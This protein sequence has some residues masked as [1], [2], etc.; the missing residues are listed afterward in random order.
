MSAHNF[1]PEEVRYEVL[2]RDDGTAMLT[3]GG[4]VMWSSDGDDEF[5]EDFGDELID[6]EDIPDL[7]DWLT[8]SG[9]LPPGVEP[10]IEDESADGPGDEDDDEEDDE[11]ESGEDE[12]D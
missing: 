3:C 1:M 2:L 6:S 8:D 4:E 5:A 10:D 12:E 9:Y 11:D 7:I